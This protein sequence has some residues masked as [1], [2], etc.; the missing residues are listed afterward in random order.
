MLNYQSTIM[1]IVYLGLMCWVN[2]DT[3]IKT[4][5]FHSSILVIQGQHSLMEFQ[6]HLKESEIFQIQVKANQDIIL[7]Y[8]K[9]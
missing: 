9:S 6:V 2:K 4:Q 1:V 5:V 7:D 3:I 8:I